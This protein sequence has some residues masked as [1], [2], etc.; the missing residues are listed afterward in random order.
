M[1]SVCSL[2]NMLQSVL[3]VA[4][5]DQSSIYPGSIYSNHYNI[6]TSLVLDLCV[7]QYPDKP[8]LIDLIDPFV[9][10]QLIPVKDGIATLP[11]DYRNILGSPYIFANPK[12]TGSC[13][14]TPDI[15]TKEQFLVVK[16][17][18]SCKVNPLEIVPQSEF[19]IRTNSTYNQPNWELP[20]AYFAG[21][22]QLKV[23]PFDIPKIYLLYVIQEPIFRYGYFLN[24]DDTFS[25]DPST[26]V[27]SIW[28]NS[29]FDPLFKALC[30]LYGIYARDQEVKD[31]ATLLSQVNIL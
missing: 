26:T 1:A 20:I 28:G 18:A 30:H 31:W 9:K 6:A 29:A 12:N 4:N 16:N 21:K 2:D 10:F 24:P 27:E 19:S 3:S 15:T 23:C 22:K 14:D 7:K 8:Y 11:D 25:F 13:G 5:E 17:T